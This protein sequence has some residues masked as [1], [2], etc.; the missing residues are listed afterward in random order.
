M[1]SFDAYNPDF[2]DETRESVLAVGFRD[3]RNPDSYLAFERAYAPAIDDGR[4]AVGVVSVDLGLE[5]L[6]LGL[7][8]GAVS[9]AKLSRDR[10]VVELDASLAGIPLDDSLIEIR[11]EIDDSEFERLRTVL[12]VL[13]G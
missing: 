5:G 2:L 9:S 12:E 7:V 1:R 11:F 13:F 6:N 8:P 3:R 10:L 4:Y